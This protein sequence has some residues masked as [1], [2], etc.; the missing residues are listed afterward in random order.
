MPHIPDDLKRIAAAQDG[1]ITRRQALDAGLS[2]HQVDWL[3]GR[4]SRW[5]VVLRG[6]YSV[7]SGRLTR[8]QELRAALLHAGDGAALTGATVL[9]LC[10]LKYAP[11]D[12]RVYVLVPINRRVRQHPAVV[13]ERSRNM[14]AVAVRD[15][16]PTAPV[17]RASVDAARHSSRREA[18]A[19]LAEVVQRRLTTLDR[20]A[21][22][23]EG[24]HQPGMAAV[25]AA[26]AALG[27]GAASAPE[28]DLV[29]ICERSSLLPPPSLNHPL[30]VDG[31]RVVADA[32][33]PEYSLQTRPNC[34]RHRCENERHAAR[35]E[36]ALFVDLLHT[37]DPE[38]L[39]LSRMRL[40][41]YRNGHREPSGRIAGACAI[42]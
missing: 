24:S 40:P 34:E 42:S 30:T 31:I 2:R 27:A 6:V 4:G 32:C 21:H 26:V 12:R 23:A 18:H 15:G 7:A 19:L 5:R 22:E 36:Q 9:E 20:L 39:L 29:S 37:P 8:R 38:S 17:E 35:H 11:K 16:L 25:R 10:G 1:L 3:I 14:P 13:V 28:L 41:L 33:W